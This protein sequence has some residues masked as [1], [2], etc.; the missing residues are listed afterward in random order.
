MNTV[1]KPLD[2]ISMCT[3]RVALG[4]DVG[5]LKYLDSLIREYADHMRSDPPVNEQAARQF[6]T[7]LY[8]HSGVH[9]PEEVI[10]AKDG[11]EA[12]NKFEMCYNPTDAIYRMHTSIP[13]AEFIREKDIPVTDNLQQ[14]MQVLQMLKESNIRE[15]MMLPEACIIKI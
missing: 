14:F 1:T 11:Q 8:I 5:E 2:G 9:L 3:F 15:L 10:F 13:Y 12:C 4:L 7:A 6:V